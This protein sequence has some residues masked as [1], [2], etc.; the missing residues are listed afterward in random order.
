MVVLGHPFY[1]AGETT[2]EDVPSFVEIHQTLQKHNVN[3]VM[4]GDTHDFEFY[5][6]KYPS[7]AGEKEMFHFVNGGG[8]AYLSI[9]S[10]VGFPADPITP[11]YTLYPRADE[12]TTKINNEA[13]F[14]KKPFLIW[15]ERFK[16]WPFGQEMVSGAFDFNRAPFFQSFLE[17]KVERSQNRVRLLL[18]GV[19]GQLRWRDVQLGGDVKPADKSDDDFVEFILPL[20]AAPQ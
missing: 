20:A 19:N 10:S 16:G 18:W 8:G 17:I 6:M 2:G 7:A 4:A 13:P 1:V 9:G 11:N 12:V 3:V 14:W 15:L 5:K